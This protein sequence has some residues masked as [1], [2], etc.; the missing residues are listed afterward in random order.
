MKIGRNDKCPCGSN[1]K[2]KHCCANKNVTRESSTPLSMSEQQF[3]GYSRE[4]LPEES[5]FDLSTDGLCC[6]V[7]TL[8]SRKANTLNEMHNTDAFISGMVIVTSGECSNVQM[9]GP[10]GSLDEAFEYSRIEHGAIRFH[11]KP[12]FI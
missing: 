4:R 1:K 5:P 11:S 8:D 3:L 2:Y 12:E 10:F 7:M 9:A 6:L